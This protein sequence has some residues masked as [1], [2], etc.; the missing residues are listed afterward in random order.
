MSVTKYPAIRREGA[1]SLPAFLLFPNGNDNCP[2]AKLVIE[3]DGSQLFESE[4][5]A[6]DLQR[7]TYLK[8]QGMTVL[9]IP[10]NAVRENFPGVCRQID[11]IIK[12]RNK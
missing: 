10:N 6:A 8:E 5:V 3:L 7:D 12:E 11:F 4:N 9:R 2:Q 1:T